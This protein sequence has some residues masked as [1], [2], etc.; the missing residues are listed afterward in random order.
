MWEKSSFCRL[1]LPS[2]R[3]KKL[4]ESE[5]SKFNNSGSVLQLYTISC[6]N[7]EIFRRKLWKGKYRFG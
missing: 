3:F 2:G 5:I 4:F 1:P 6:C 7:A